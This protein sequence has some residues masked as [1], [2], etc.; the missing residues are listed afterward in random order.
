MSDPEALLAREESNLAAE[1]CSENEPLEI[2]HFV[3][4]FTYD[5]PSDTPMFSTADASK[6][7]DVNTQANVGDNNLSHLSETSL[8]S[9]ELTGVDSV[10]CQCTTLG[11]VQRGRSDAQAQRCRRSRGRERGG[12]QGRRA[13]SCLQSRGHGKQQSSKPRVGR[14][15]GTTVTKGRGKQKRKRW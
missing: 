14:P 13:R 10:R 1:H 9:G 6:I 15:L 11:K 7:G 12:A 3:S 4:V 2:N 5:T 8:L